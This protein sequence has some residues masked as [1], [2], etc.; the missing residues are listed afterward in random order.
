VWSGDNGSTEVAGATRRRGVEIET[1]Y[2]LT[3]WLA[4]DLD[5]TFTRAAFRAK[6]GRGEGLA[7][8][9]KRT[10]A[11]GLSARHA[12][13]PGVLRG[14]V[15]FFGIGNR[16]ATD[17]G[18]LVAYGF[19]QFD[20]HLG[21]RYDRFDLALDIENLLNGTYRSA[22]FVTTSRL[23]GEP[24]LGAAVPDGFSCGKN[25]RLATAPE[26]GSAGGFYGCED[27]SYT[28]AYPFALRVLATVFLD[29]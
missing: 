10:W 4:A 2:E 3:K 8:A 1:R 7:L 9:P 6:S 20:V 21:Y 24:A 11:G 26:G 28:P 5:V 25:A 27:V 22:Q 13:G 15:R 19:T 23:R 29:R 14:G 12:L 18:E 16:P 17:D